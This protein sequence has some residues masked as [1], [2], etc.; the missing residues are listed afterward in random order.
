LLV[1]IAIAEFLAAYFLWQ[2]IRGDLAA[3]AVVTRPP[4]MVGTT[5]DTVETF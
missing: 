5:T 2:R 4:D 3:L 1:L